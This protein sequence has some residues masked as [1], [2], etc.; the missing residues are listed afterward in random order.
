MINNLETNDNIVEIFRKSIPFLQGSLRRYCEEFVIETRNIGIHEGFNNLKGKVHSKRLK[1]LIK[2]LYISSKH[3]ADFDKI[4]NKSKSIFAN[5]FKLK[6]K[7]K[8]KVRNGRNTIIVLIGL[9]ILVIKMI[10]GFTN[11]L[12]SSLLTTNSGQLIILYFVVLINFT[13]Y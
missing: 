13:I 8:G 5:Y 2:N 6:E 10:E 9:A 4:L 3:E 1:L 12:V 11:N 7:R